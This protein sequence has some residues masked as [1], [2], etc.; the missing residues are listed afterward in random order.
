MEEFYHKTRQR[1]GIVD[2]TIADTSCKP[3]WKIIGSL[4]GECLKYSAG[5]QEFLRNTELHISI[6]GNDSGNGF[7]F[8]NNSSLRHKRYPF[9]LMTLAPFNDGI[10]YTVH[11]PNV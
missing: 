4:E 6:L 5:L 11:V 9:R 10:L 7:M 8:S 3:H 1:F 2:C